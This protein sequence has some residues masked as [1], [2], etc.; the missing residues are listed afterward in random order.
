MKVIARTKNDDLIVEIGEDEL[1]K[2]AGFA[3]TYSMPSKFKTNRSVCLGV[4]IDVGE[5]YKDATEALEGHKDAV[6]AAS[7]LK[8]AS[9]RFLK[10]FN[11]A[12]DAPKP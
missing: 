10:F 7:S 6:K 1:A 9:S 11:V 3:S 5:I 12:E 8:R 4:D 2:M